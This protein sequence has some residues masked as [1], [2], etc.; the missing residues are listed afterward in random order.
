M[1]VRKKTWVSII[2]ILLPD[3]KCEIF[4]M[5]KKDDREEDNHGRLLPLKLKIMLFNHHI[6]KPTKN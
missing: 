1:S 3:Q 4:D 2:D 6:E 5:G